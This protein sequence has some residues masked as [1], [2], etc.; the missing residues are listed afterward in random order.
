MGLRGKVR[1]LEDRAQAIAAE[2]EADKR[3]SASVP[4]W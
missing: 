2:R 1:R 4:S 3:S